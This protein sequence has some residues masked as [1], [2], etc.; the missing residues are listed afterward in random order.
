MRDGMRWKGWKAFRSAVARTKL[1]TLDV[2]IESPEGIRVWSSVSMSNREDS[3]VG[4]LLVSAGAL[5]SPDRQRLAGKRLAKDGSMRVWLTSTPNTRRCA[6]HWHPDSDWWGPYRIIPGRQRGPSIPS[7]CPAFRCGPRSRSSWPGSAL[8]L[9][10]KTSRSGIQSRNGVSREHRMPTNAQPSFASSVD[11][12]LFA[13]LLLRQGQRFDDSACILDTVHRMRGVHVRLFLSFRNGQ[14]NPQMAVPSKRGSWSEWTPGR[15]FASIF[16]M[17]LWTF[18]TRTM[19]TSRI[20]CRDCSRSCGCTA[21]L[22]SSFPGTT[23]AVP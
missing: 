17:A 4:C 2:E 22:A 10:S 1:A 7:D 23:N 11:A 16:E 21:S 15:G 12:R 18:A 9:G 14:C 5:Q 19:A 6:G 20:E 13:C 8:P 3:E